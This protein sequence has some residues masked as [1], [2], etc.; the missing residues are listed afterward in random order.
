M[1]NSAAVFSQKPSV[2]K[3]AEANKAHPYEQIGKLQIQNDWF[4]KKLQ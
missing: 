4:K 2:S 3:D 1:E